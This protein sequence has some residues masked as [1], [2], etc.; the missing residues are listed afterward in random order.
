[1][2]PSFSFRNKYTLSKLFISSSFMIPFNTSILPK[3][4]SPFY[5]SK[6]EYFSSLIRRRNFLDPATLVL[7]PT[8][9][10]LD[11]GVMTNGSSPE[12]FRYFIKKFRGKNPFLHSFFHHVADGS[13]VGF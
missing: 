3:N 2:P 5:I 1:M 10:K 11:S 4:C 9:I 13:G 7:S 6:L 12:S 8:L